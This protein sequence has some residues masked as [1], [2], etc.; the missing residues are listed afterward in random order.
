M[1]ESYFEIKKKE[2]KIVN[3]QTL[4]SQLLL[5]FGAHTATLRF[6]AVIGLFR[7]QKKPFSILPCTTIF[8]N[9]Y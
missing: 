4:S 8:P 6:I 9:P 2:K 7:E 1:K 3:K 5:T